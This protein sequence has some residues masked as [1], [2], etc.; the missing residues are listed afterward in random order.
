MIFSL[1]LVFSAYAFAQEY[2]TPVASPRQKIEQQFSI[3]KIGID[4]GRPGA[5][6]RQVFGGIVPFG[7]IW[8]AGANAVTKISFGQEV[9]FN[10]KKVGAGTY[11]LF[12]LP[13]KDTWKIILNTDTKQWGAFNYDAKLNVAEVS[14]PVLS[15]DQPVEWFTINFTPN[16]NTDLDMDISWEKSKVIVPIKIVDNEAVSKIIKDLKAEKAK[17]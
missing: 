9:D 7:K 14:V 4:Y 1:A 11:A 15:L 12:I 3:S 6:G 16:G 10:G 2:T 13:E 17:K 5:K 8:R